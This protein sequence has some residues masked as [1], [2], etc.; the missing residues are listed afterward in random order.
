L[1]RNLGGSSDFSRGVDGDMGLARLGR[2]TITVLA[3][4]SFHVCANSA[5][6]LRLVVTVKNPA[7]HLGP[8]NSY[9]LAIANLMGHSV[10]IR[11][12]ILI[13]KQAPSGWTQQGAIEAIDTCDK[14]D[15]KFSSDATVRLE[16]HGTLAVVPSDGWLCGEQ[17]PQ[18]CQQN[19][20]HMPGIYRFVVVTANDGV[21]IVSPQ[22]SIEWLEMFIR[23]RNDFHHMFTRFAE[24]YSLMID[25]MSNHEISM[26]RGIGIWKREPTGWSLRGGVQAVSKCD[27][28]DAEDRG[29][30]PIRIPS[31]GTFEVVPWD[32][33]MCG[34]QCEQ[35]CMKNYHVGPGTFR[36][37]V[38]VLP[39]GT[40]IESSPFTIK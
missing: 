11:K 14:Y 39:E 36:F 30:T 13:E 38:V 19:S 18:P 6:P 22:F 37:E 25:N 34:G 24:S 27:D 17:C 23:P 29:E 28:F 1:R 10:A 3:V 20:P 12:N 35:S 40:K 16:A 31:F 21:R 2:S 7:P 8:V 26:R 4:A 9:G 32:G 33:T 15:Y 5:E